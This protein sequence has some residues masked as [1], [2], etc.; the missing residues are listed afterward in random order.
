MA[1]PSAPGQIK[2]AGN[3]ATPPIGR[4]VPKVELGG[5]HIPRVSTPAHVWCLR[6]QQPWSRASGGVQQAVTLT[7]HTNW[8]TNVIERL[9]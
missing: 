1:K 9:Y 2:T 7:G 8:Q 3:R 4:S 5:Q 6:L